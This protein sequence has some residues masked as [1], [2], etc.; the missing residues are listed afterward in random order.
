[1]PPST[2]FEVYVYPQMPPRVT[3]EE[4]FDD[5][6][7]LPLPPIPLKRQPAVPE[8]STSRQVSTPPPP[9]Q[10]IPVPTNEPARKDNLISDITP[11][12]RW[13]SIYPI[14]I[15]AKRPFAKGQRR[16]ARS[17]SVWWPLSKD[18]AQAAQVIGIQCLHESNKSHPRDWENPG[19]IKVLW[20]KDGE[21]VYQR[22]KTRKQ[23]IE[24]LSSAIQAAK[25][26]LKPSE[27][28]EAHPHSHTAGGPSNAGPSTPS[29]ST[30]KNKSK[31]KSKSSGSGT[32]QSGKKT[33]RAKKKTN[34]HSNLPKPPKPL[35][36]LSAR[37]SIYSPAIES[38]IVKETF[39]MGMDKGQLPGS[40]MFLGG[41]NGD[42]AGG[43]GGAPGGM[44]GPGGGGMPGAGGSKGKRKVVRVRG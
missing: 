40:E 36:P 4:V 1:L 3:V 33:R 7:E 25:P 17:K 21:L 28:V 15:D 32:T 34:K 18:L 24:L 11:Y 10:R 16:I 12:K 20:K 31:S 2:W 37:L 6:T 44:G 42:G 22:A 14:Y 39:K 38:G 27:E 29:S 9:P 8:L 26:D 30:S 13:T 41:G 35:P 19:R 43:S 5:D 23:L